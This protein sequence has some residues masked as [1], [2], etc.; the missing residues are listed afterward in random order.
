MYSILSHY[1]HPSHQAEYQFDYEFKGTDNNSEG[2]YNMLVSVTAI[3][4]ICFISSYIVYD[5]S[6]QDILND[7]EKEVFN[8]IYSPF[9]I[10]LFGNEPSKEEYLQER[11]NL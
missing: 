2:P 5:N 6:L 8:V 11:Q 7:E 9:C 1:A 3:L 4:A 10:G